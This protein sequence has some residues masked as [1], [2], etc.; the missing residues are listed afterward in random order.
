MLEAVDCMQ[1]GERLRKKGCKLDIKDSCYFELIDEEKF[2]FKVSFE[3]RGFH[4]LFVML[5]LVKLLFGLC[6]F[7]AL[8]L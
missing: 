7:I 3:E 8:L 4:E 6:Y 2:V 1:V 5:C